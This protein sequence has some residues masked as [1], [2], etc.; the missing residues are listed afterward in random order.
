MRANDGEARVALI[1]L[2]DTK[3]LWAKQLASYAAFNETAYKIE[4][5][6]GIAFIS[7]DRLIAF[8]NTENGSAILLLAGC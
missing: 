4:N 7:A 1:S 5:H 6:S 2:R 8:G 3:E